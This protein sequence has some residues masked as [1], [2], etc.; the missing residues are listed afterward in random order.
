MGPGKA[1]YR[2]KRLAKLNVNR[3]HEATKQ[4]LDQSDQT[5]GNQIKNFIKSCQGE[6]KDNLAAVLYDIN[7]LRLEQRPM[8]EIGPKDVL[9]AVDC[10]GICRTDVEYWEKGRAGPYVVE[11]PMILGRE[12]SGIVVE[13]GKQVQHLRKGDRVAVEPGESCRHCQLCRSGQYNLCPSIRFCA[14]PPNDGLLTRYAKHPA[15]LCYKLPDHV[16]MEEGALLEP[17][18]VGMAS[19]RRAKVGLGSEVLILGC[20]PIGLTTLA[21]ATSIG[22][23]KVL[24]V[25]KKKDR[26]EIAKSFGADTLHLNE[27]CNPKDLAQSIHATMGCIPDKC[28]DC[29]GTIESLKLAIY[30]TRPGGMCTLVGVPDGKIVLPLIDAMSREVDILGVV[31]YRNEYLSYHSYPIALAMA[32]SFELSLPAIISHH[33]ALEQISLAFETAKLQADGTLKV[34]PVANERKTHLI[35]P[36]V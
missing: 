32:A 27:N 7:D 17:L 28:F 26:L 18:A 3:C 5:L 12:A 4:K 9:L 23:S 8:P 25:D 36:I 16:T 2:K 11:E 1:K 20:G 34:K 31:N 15:H 21:T 33:F 30:T 22:A 24:I 13:S 19:C 29:V 35:R 14:T 6:N 10:V